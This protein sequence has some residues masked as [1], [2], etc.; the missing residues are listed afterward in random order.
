ML[1]VIDVEVADRV[2]A[3]CEREQSAGRARSDGARAAF[4]GAEHAVK[5]AAEAVEKIG[6]DYAQLATTYLKEKQTYLTMLLQTA[7]PPT[8]VNYA[9]NDFAD[10]SPSVNR[11]RAL[12]GEPR[13]TS[14]FP[15]LPCRRA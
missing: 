11:L 2:L 5:A 8:L 13:P 4:K 10:N 3:D 6:D 7:Q 12:V 14:S 1:S 9:P 15:I